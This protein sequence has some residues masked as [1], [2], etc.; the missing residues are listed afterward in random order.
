MYMK[1]GVGYMHVLYAYQV[2]FLFPFLFFPF[3]SFPSFLGNAYIC[4]PC[5]IFLLV[6]YYYYLSLHSFI[7][8]TLTY[9][10]VVGV[11]GMC[12]LLTYNAI[13]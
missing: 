1:L 4:N 11:V 8:K 12:K 3:P 2:M 9:M 5:L 7:F 6:F 10:Y 13:K